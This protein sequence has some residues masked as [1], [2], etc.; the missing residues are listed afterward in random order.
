[1]RQ[2]GRG[3]TVYEWGEAW[4]AK[5]SPRRVLRGGCWHDPPALCRSAARLQQDP[6]QGEDFFGMRV[7]LFVQE[8]A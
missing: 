1:M 4:E 5:G 2:W 3:I 6:T 7:A 8:L